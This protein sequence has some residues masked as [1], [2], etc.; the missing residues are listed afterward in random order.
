MHKDEKLLSEAYTSILEKAD[1][2]KYAV[3]GCECGECDECI[4]KKHSNKEEPKEE[5]ENKT[6]AK[7]KVKESVATTKF[8]Q[9][10]NDILDWFED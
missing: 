3:D 10:Y 9:A 2:C 4:E 5:K 7:Q 6:K 8:D 1:H